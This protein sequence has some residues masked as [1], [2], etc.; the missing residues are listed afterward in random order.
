MCNPDKN[1][2][3][4]C[5]VRKYLPGNST[6]CICKYGSNG[7]NHDPNEIETV[8][9][10]IASTTRIQNASAKSFKD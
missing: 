10:K 8:L 9:L 7:V 3:W 5:G 6:Q 1:T 4:L 2:C